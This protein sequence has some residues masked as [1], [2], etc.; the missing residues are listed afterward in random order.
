MHAWNFILQRRPGGGGFDRGAMPLRVD[1][2]IPTSSSTE[3]QLHPQW[4]RSAAIQKVNATITS[5]SYV[6]CKQIEIRVDSNE[7]KRG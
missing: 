1:I 5:H 4:T 6:K 2:S 7:K 3:S